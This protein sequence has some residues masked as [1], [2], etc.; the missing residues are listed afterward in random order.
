MVVVDDDLGGPYPPPS[1]EP[2]SAALRD[3]GFDVRVMAEPDPASRPDHAGR[4][5]RYPGDA[6]SEHIAGAAGDGS[7]PAGTGVQSRH[8]G[9]RGGVGWRAASE[10]R[11]SLQ[12]MGGSSWQ[13]IDA[14]PDAVYRALLDT[15]KYTRM[16]PAVT[17]SRLVTE[18]EGARIIRL[19]HKRG[20]IGLSYDVRAH[21]Y[22][23]RRDVTFRL[24][25][26]FGVWDAEPL[27]NGNLLITEFSVN[28][29]S[30]LTRE[31]KVVWSFD[32]LR[33]PYD[34][35]RLAIPVVDGAADQ[36]ACAQR[37]ER[38]WYRRR[39]RGCGTRD[40]RRRQTRLAH[41]GFAGRKQ[42]QQAR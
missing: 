11:G 31:N 22:P 36:L 18:Q 32:D 5:R 30:E 9:G 34:A 38:A 26:I 12:L 7:D 15:T 1:R 27:A 23:E 19:E 35:D 40:G 4:A 42:E 16:L 21:F 20:P 6:R 3:A 39:S 14:P 24:E 8:G 33:N 13:L 29:V 41:A 28:R 25:D 17:A 37:A 2:F 10:E